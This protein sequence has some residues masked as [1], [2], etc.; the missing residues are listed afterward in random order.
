[1]IDYKKLSVEQI[2]SMDEVMDNFDFEK[3]Q[4][5]MDCLKWSWGH[6]SQIPDIYEIRQF[7]KRLLAD[8]YIGLSHLIEDK[9]LTLSTGGF[10]ATA[11]RD[12][13]LSLS[14]VVEE[15]EHFTYED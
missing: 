7:A 2:Q 5:V 10:T 11:Y 3:V 4:K 15:W 8:A 13:S 9:S 1:M 12:G 14:F 6:E